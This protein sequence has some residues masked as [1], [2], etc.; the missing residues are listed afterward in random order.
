MTDH[1]DT[2]PSL[3]DAQPTQDDSRDFDC[4]SSDG[5]PGLWQRLKA[6]WRGE[7]ER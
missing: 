3:S 5:E 6:A 4:S 1:G 2:G 7:I